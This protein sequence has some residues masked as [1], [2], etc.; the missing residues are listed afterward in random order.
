MQ[1]FVHQAE[2]G[3]GAGA[4]HYFG[5][6][7]P[8]AAVNRPKANAGVFFRKQFNNYMSVRLSG[9]YALLGYA[10]QYSNN[11]VQQR[12][13]LSFNSHVWEAAVSFDFN[14]FTFQPGFEDF[15]FTPYV[16][17]GVGAFSYD[18]YAF[19]DNQKYFLRPLGTEGQGSSAYPTF[20]TY[21]PIAVSVP[22]TLGVKYA[23]S[24]QFN[25]FA[26]LMYRFTNTDYLDDVSGVYAPDAFP[27]LPDG[28]PSP[29]FL[30]QD[31]SYETGN[32]I[33][34]K[35]RQ[36]GNTLQTDVFAGLKL[37]ISFNLQTYKCPKPVQ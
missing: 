31:R 13:N 2:F 26:E 3:I 18:P 36:R 7:N 10:D 27:T 5:D 24:E 29:A 4:A 33:G 14:F 16:G 25:V 9:E 22:L 11:T 1:S 35:G 28:S 20:K 6:L 30:L 37:G 34:I 17:V 12:R 32:P 19:L 23:L 21:A 8:T 15:R